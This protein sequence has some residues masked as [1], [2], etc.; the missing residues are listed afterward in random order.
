MKTRFATGPLKIWLYARIALH[1]ALRY[2]RPTRIAGWTPVVY[3]RFLRR[4]LMLLLAFRHNKMVRTHA[5]WKLHL[6]FPA[7]PSPAFFH[8]LDS[9]LVRRPPAPV[10]VVFSMTKACRY[11]C[12]HCYQRLDR[13][14]DLD[15]NLMLDTARAMQEAGV[16]LFDLEGGEPL[17]RFPRLLRLMRALDERA[18]LWI[19]TT[20][21]GL[22]PAQVADLKEAR[23]FGVMVSVH[24]PDAAQHDALTG[25]PGSFERAVRT[26]RMFHESAVVTAINSV[27]SESEIRDGQLERLMDFARECRCDFVQLIHPKPAGN[28]LARREQMQ[29]SREVLARI[30]RDHV[31]YNS[32]ACRALP[33]LAAQVFEESARVL[34]CTAGGVD[35]FYLNAHGEVQPCE[36]LNVSFGN[37]AD[38]PFAKI[39]ARMRETFREPACD[40]L[41]CTQCDAIRNLA[42]RYALSDM[43]LRWPQTR[44]LV[45]QWRRGPPTPLYRRLGLYR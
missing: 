11:R 19:N 31:R 28:W 37:V 44:E 12:A 16:A 45:A 24:S 20:G 23:L 33:A 2:A 27:L 38:E 43:P 30:E 22:T 5:G 18:E 25:T 6:Y 21:D 1:V 32:R 7:Y 8:A 17:M 34:G 14:S 10:T 42:E 3:V 9:K 4:A 15:E 36:F 29:T 35:R 39:F 13:G 41:C 40:W 26:L